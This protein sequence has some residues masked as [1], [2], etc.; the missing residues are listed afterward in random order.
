IF[1]LPGGTLKPGAV[2]DI[3]L[4]DLNYPWIVKSDNM[5]SS[6]RNTAFEKS[7]FSGRIVETYVSGKRV[8]A[9]ES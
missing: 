7:Q 1:N 4:I 8:Y 9:L 2:A 5:F 6:Y 3:I